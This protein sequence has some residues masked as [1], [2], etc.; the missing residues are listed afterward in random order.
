M[1]AIEA[2][3]PT[4]APV[5]SELLGGKWSLLYTGASAEDAAKRRAKEV[6][7]AGCLN[8]NDNDNYVTARDSWAGEVQHPWTEGGARGGGGAAATTLPSNG[9]KP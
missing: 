7:R 2:L 5:E 4:A 1:E 3:N 8:Y 9:P 6:R